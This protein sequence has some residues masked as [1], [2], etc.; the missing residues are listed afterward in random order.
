LIGA[1][2]NVLVGLAFID[3]YHNYKS[4]VF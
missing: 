3:I 4:A 2:F 1:V